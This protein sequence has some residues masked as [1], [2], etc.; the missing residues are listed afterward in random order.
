MKKTLRIIIKILSYIFIKIINKIL[1]KT[2]YKILPALNDLKKLDFIY[3]K[4]TR[5]LVLGNNKNQFKKIYIDTSFYD[6]ELCNLGKKYSSNKSPMNLGGHRSGFSGLYSIL[7]FQQKNRKIK[8]AEI[9]I[10]KNASTQMWRKYFKDAEIHGFEF[11][12]QKIKRAKK[13][14]LKKTFYHKTDV[15]NPKIIDESFKKTKIKYDIIIDDSTHIFEHQINVINECFKYLNKDGILIIED[16][17][18]NDNLYNES[19]YYNRLKKIKKNF[20]EIVFIETLNMNNY[21]AGWKNEKILFFV[22]K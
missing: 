10:E 9:G 22:K 8:L 20:R 17:Y 3:D 7:F 21:T 18:K 11:D 4:K 5:R 15:T 1:K 6:S 19:N 13:Q 12:K 14:K 16:I 2:N